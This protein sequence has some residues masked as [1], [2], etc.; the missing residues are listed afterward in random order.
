M[1]AKGKLIT[2]AV[3]IVAVIVSSIFYSDSSS[4]F[5]ESVN[6]NTQ[7]SVSSQILRIGY[8]PNINHAQAVIG[9]G[10]GTFQKALGD[11][12][13]VKT[14]IFNAGPS[15][16]EALFAKQVDV[17]YVGP[18]PA[19]NAYV[20]S[21]GKD[22][23]IISGASSGGAVFVVRNDSGIQSTKDFANKKFASPQLGNTQ[24]VAL[25]KYLVDNGYKTKEN[26]GNVEVVS[27]KPSDILTLMLK[28]EIDGAWVP[29]PW[30]AR[31][32]KEANARIFLDE[33]DLWPPKGQFVTSNIVARTDYLQS[34]PDVIKKLLTAHVDE[35]EWINSHKEET[36]KAFNVEL[37]KLTG[38]AIPEDQLRGAL[39]R[40]DLT[41]DPVKESLF[42][43]A[44]SAFDIGFLGKTRPDLSGIYNL[45]LLNTVISEREKETIK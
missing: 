21:Q 10:N 15:A 30:G 33:R 23:R 18:N 16:M 4:L 44:N 29:E 19:I 38:Q 41:Y 8:F 32:I 42:Q 1:N 2:S 31:L 36:I 40:M 5:V 3:I 24:D 9:L 43:S 28:R 39:T 27:A 45:D 12:V 34:N 22:V 7:N 14:T 35:T 13:E 37:K 26:G 17:T 25:R 6:D 20:V 11:N